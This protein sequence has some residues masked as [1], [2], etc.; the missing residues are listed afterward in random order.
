MISLRRKTLRNPR[1]STRRASRKGTKVT[2]TKTVPA[3]A[4]TTRTQVTKIAKTVMKRQVETQ[5]I[6]DNH[7]LNY[8]AIY[9]DTT[10]T[11]GAVQVFGALPQIVQSGGEQSYGCRGVKIEPTKHCSD[12][13]FCFSPELLISSGGPATRIDSVAWDVT[14]H[15]WYGYVRRYKS[16]DDVNGNKIFIAQNLLR[17]MGLLRHAF[18]ARWEI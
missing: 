5:Y 3:L 16:M 13:Q 17:S 14:V 11:G 9:G 6:C 2:V 4:P 1:G 18:Q 15:V 7:E 12:L 10:P 8:S